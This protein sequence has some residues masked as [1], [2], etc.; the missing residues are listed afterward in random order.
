MNWF[1]RSD[2]LYSWEMDNWLLFVGLFYEDERRASFLFQ[3]LIL[4]NQAL[5]RTYRLYP[6]VH[7]ILTSRQIIFYVPHDGLF[8]MFPQITIICHLSQAPGNIPI[9]SLIGLPWSFSLDPEAMLLVDW[10]YMSGHVRGTTIKL[11]LL[12]SLLFQAV[13]WDQTEYMP[14]SPLNKLEFCAAVSVKIFKGRVLIKCWVGYSC[15]EWVIPVRSG[16]LMCGMGYFYA[17]WAIPVQSGLLKYG[18]GCSSAKWVTPVRNELFQCRVAYS[19]TELDI[20]AEWFTPVGNV[21]LMCE[22]N[23]SCAKSV[24]QGR[25]E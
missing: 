13:T 23:Y 21:L 18:V 22:V 14:G 6:H 7:I 4:T 12:L 1:S 10:I 3:V 17:E 19:S 24:T 25:S 16:L 8:P 9:C 5:F 15:T 20:P 2:D 11:T